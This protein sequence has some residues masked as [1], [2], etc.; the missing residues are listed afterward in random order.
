MADQANTRVLIA[1]IGGASLGTEVLK[2]LTLAGGYD[3]FGCDVSPL[4]YGHHGGGF[5]ATRVIRRG[6][7]YLDDVLA[8]CRDES[9]RFLIPG[10]E[11]PLSLLSSASA[12]LA[13]AGVE[14]LAN[15]PS[16]V[17]ECSHK[18]LLFDR[19]RALGVAI[20]ATV[21][22]AAELDRMTY[23]CVVKPATGS[24]G[25]SFVFLSQSREETAMYVDYLDRNGRPVVVQQYIPER[26]G[27]FTVGVL[28]LPDGS[29]V[30]SI[31]LRRAFHSKL[32]VLIKSDAGLISTGYSQGLIDHFPEVQRTCERIALALDSRGPLN[33]QGRLHDGVF[34]PFEIN[35]RFSASTYL[36][37]MAGFNEIDL[38]IKHRQ[39]KPVAAPAIRPGHYLRS[40][41][42]AFA[43]R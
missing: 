2:C 41:T 36:R 18:G 29:L 8:L 20:P 24:G 23:P 39:G 32:S 35:P 13:D 4:A 5:A 40:L 17:A 37:A 42:E 26:E 31:A 25:S 9:I 21:R 30:G 43:P 11:E 34:Y 14:L 7:G 38:F 12:R 10:G 3:V 16:V 28:S 33:V 1:G 27:E 19:L 22:S 6:E 15:T